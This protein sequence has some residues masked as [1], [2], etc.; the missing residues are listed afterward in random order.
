M[1]L[2][3]GTSGEGGAG[4]TEPE[5]DFTATIVRTTYGIPHI[6]GDDFGDQSV[7]LARPL[8]TARTGPR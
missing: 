1:Q 6:T 2:I 4:G 5:R 8:D 7:S 3:C